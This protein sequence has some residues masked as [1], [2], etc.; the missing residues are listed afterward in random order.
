MRRVALTYDA[1][2]AYDLRVMLG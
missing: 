1:R 2:P